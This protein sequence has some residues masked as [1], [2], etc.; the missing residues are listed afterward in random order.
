MAGQC[1]SQRP[2]RRRRQRERSGLWAPS[3]ATVYFD[4]FA[5]DAVKSLDAAGFA[6]KYKVPFV[7]DLGCDPLT[8]KGLD[9]VQGSSLALTANERAALGSRGFV[10]TDR[11]RYPSFVYGY[12]TIY[13]EDLPVYVSADSIL[14]AVHSSFDAILKTLEN[15]ALVPALDRLLAGMQSALREGAGS[16]ISAA[17]RV[18]AD[19]YVAVARSLLS[20]SF[21]APSPAEM[22]SRHGGSS[23]ARRLLPEQRK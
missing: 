3:G 7:T 6:E 5:L 23:T 16:N 13:T 14:Y 12:Q 17:A 9:R 20:D 1:S 21:I 10:T 8:A 15:E 11:K 4:H 2:R 18:D 19:L 22:P